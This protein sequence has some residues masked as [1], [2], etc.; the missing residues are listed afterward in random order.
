VTRIEVA[1][2]VAA[3]PAS[4]ALLLSGPAARDA[5]PSDGDVRVGP[6]MRSGVGFVADM[7]V[8]DS[9]DR[10]VRGRYTIMP[11]EG[12]SGASDVRLVLTSTADDPRSLREVGEA[13][14]QRLSEWASSRSS[15]A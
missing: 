15:A 14:V 2:Q 9:T 5:W 13:C 6:P 8:V 3:D 12:T 1:R 11:A 4:V 7:T 10:G